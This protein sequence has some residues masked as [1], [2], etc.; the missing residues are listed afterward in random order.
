MAYDLKNRLVIGLAS[1][2]LFDLSA[3]DAVFRNSGEAAYRQYQQDNINQ[4]LNK[5]VAFPFIKR[6]LSINEIQPGDPPIEVVLLSRNDPQTGLRVMH[7]IKHYGL[8]ITRAAFLQGRV[9]HKYIPA[10]S[11]ALFL[12]ANEDDV[13]QAVND[14]YPA[15]QVLPSTLNDDAE[16][17]EL[18][19]AFDFDG[20]LADDESEAVY[21]QNRNIDE[22]HRH[23][24]DKTDI[25]HNPGPLKDFLQK[26]SHVQH[27]EQEYA[28]KNSDYVP[29][30]RISIVTARSAPAHERVIN[31]MRSWGITVNDAFFLGGIEKAKVLKVLS[32]HMFFDDQRTHLEP[33]AQLLSSVHIPF[34]VTNKQS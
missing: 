20:V 34:G 21:Q 15:G 28:E 12:S 13:R 25:P 2:A 14:G 4:P 18:R 17:K 3:S 10:L 6:L 5:G 8:D 19:I 32:P 11:I 1:S 27:L 31:S 22:F 23:E 9:P 29:K 33:A 30:I 7:S 24:T 16:D 26:L